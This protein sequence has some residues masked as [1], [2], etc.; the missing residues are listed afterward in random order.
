MPVPEPT[1]HRIAARALPLAIL[2]LALAVLAWSDTAHRIVMRAFAAANG[3]IVE[4]EALG[5]VAFVALA[6]LSAMLAFF[7]SAVLVPAAVFAWGPVL[8]TAL[9]ALG[10]IL[11]GVTSYSLARWIGRPVLGVLAPGRSFRPYEQRLTSRTTFGLVVLLQLALPSEIP[12]VV[13]GLVRYP[14]GRYV[15]ALALAELPYAIG[16][17]LLGQSFVERRLLA[18]VSLGAVAALAATLSVRALRRRLGTPDAS[19]RPQ[20]DGSP[21]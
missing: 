2:V 11:G 5:M 18:L 20:S 15:V 1:R 13:L 6:A 7:S 8:A 14:L 10:W 21:G 4:H 9:L 3:V 12:G 19:A 16:T 17:V